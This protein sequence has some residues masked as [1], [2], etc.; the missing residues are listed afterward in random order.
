MC[1]HTKSVFQKF[2]LTSSK[3]AH[4]HADKVGPLTPSKRYR[5]I[6]S[7]I[8]C[9]SRW[10]EAIPPP[11]ITAQPV[12]DAFM[13]H[14]VGCYGVPETIIVDRGRQFTSTLWHDLMT[15]LGS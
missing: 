14:F 10:P 13:L 11:V 5:Y 3:F 9:F 6:L 2:E 12:V 7:I 8:N 1:V 4:V 15:F